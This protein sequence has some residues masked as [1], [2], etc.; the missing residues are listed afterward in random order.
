MS[1]AHRSWFK[2]SRDHNINRPKSIGWTIFNLISVTFLLSSAKV[3][4]MEGS[5]SAS[6]D[7]SLMDD[8]YSLKADL[9]AFEELRKNIPPEKR[10]E[11][12]EKAFMD[13]MMSDLTKSPAEVR[14]RYSS[15][16]NKKRDLFNKDMI[17]ARQKF[18]GEE[19]KEREKYTKEQSEVR[20]DFS[21][22]KVTSDERREFF[23]ELEAKR[24]EFYLEQKEK[25]DEFEEEIRGKRRNFDDYMRAKADE[26][27]QLHRDYTK[28][29]E[30]NKKLQADLKRKNEEKKKQFIKD[31]DQEYDPVRKKDPTILEPA[32]SE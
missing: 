19:K 8:K 23:Q 27:N 24:K 29:Y 10:K 1:L 20:K 25:R 3:Y 31:L 7:S 30:E 18:S 28:R 22:K 12:D 13:Q 17:K 21:K 11:N 15:I 14:G 9:N 16:V 5:T 26:F 32:I 4:G 2:A 6:S